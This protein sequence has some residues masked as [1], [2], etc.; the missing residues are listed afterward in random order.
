M[1]V[2]IGTF[3]ISALIPARPLDYATADD[4]P[5][6]ELPRRGPPLNATPVE[7]AEQT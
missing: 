4:D 1:V 6:P 3:V 5:V 7:R 2:A